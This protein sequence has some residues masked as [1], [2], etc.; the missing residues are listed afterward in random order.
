MKNRMIAK[1]ELFSCQHLC[2]YT[3]T[4]QIATYIA[5]LIAIFVSKLIEWLTIVVVRSD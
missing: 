3:F 4:F 2:S 5:G 1:F